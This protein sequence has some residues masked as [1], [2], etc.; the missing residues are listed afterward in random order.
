[1]YLFDEEIF[2]YLF[3]FLNVFIYL[4]I[5]PMITMVTAIVNSA[6]VRKKK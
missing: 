3:V 5:Y 4:S 6:E 2:M 1:M